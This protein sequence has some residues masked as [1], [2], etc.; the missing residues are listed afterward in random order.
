[1]PDVKAGLAAGYTPTH[2][3]RGCLLPDIQTWAANWGVSPTATSA[4]I[5]GSAKVKYDRER[6]AMVE[7]MRVERWWLDELLD[8]I[9]AE[10][11]E[12]EARLRGR[13]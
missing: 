1:M 12:E 13:K 5:N 6:R 7:T 8:L 10:R 3:I 4:L 2:A 11:L 9:R